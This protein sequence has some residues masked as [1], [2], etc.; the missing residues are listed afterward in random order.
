M[1]NCTSISCAGGACRDDT[2]KIVCGLEELNK[3]ATI[4]TDT[5]IV[6]SIGGNNQWEFELDILSRT[7]CDVHTFDCTGPRSRFQVPNNPRLHFHHACL[8]AYP[9]LVGE[10]RP[11]FMRGQIWTLLKMQQRLGHKRIDLLKV[12]IEGWEFPLFESWPDLYRTK[13]SERILLPMQL[14]VEVCTAYGWL[15]TAFSPSPRL[16]CFLSLLLGTLPNPV[17]SI[18]PG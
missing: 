18:A 3:E 14:L 17:S 9:E 15:P 5:C 6:Y 10:P 12:D 1:T 2:S 7:T 8:S 4:K 13:E 11:G 16:T